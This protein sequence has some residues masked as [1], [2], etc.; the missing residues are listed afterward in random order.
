MSQNT[1]ESLSALM[2]NESDE[3]ELRRV[4]KSLPDDADAAETWRRY[5]LARS[6]MQRERS[7][8]VS[9]DLSAGIMA[10]LEDEPVPSVESDVTTVP[11]RTGGISFARGA[12]VAAAVSLM[13]ITGVQF[14]NGNGSTGTAQ[15]TGNT[16]ASQSNPGTQVQPVSLSAAQ[17]ASM[18]ASDMPMFEPTPFRISG[19]SGSSGL[20]NISETGFSTPVAPQGMM[21]Q[22][23]TTIDVDQLRMLQSYLEQHAQGAAI[24]GGDSWTPL[25]RSSVTEPLG[26]R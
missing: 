23:A 14:F 20:M 11:A 1:R 22:Q 16:V 9:V 24:G 26:Q 7:V 17:P 4:L 3:L 25:M 19:Q 8:D 5:H 15:P 13:V 10:R 21:A 12:G 6:M 18:V 2:D